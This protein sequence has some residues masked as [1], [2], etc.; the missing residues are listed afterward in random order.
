MKQLLLILFVA[1]ILLSCGKEDGKKDV[2]S[3]QIK[4]ISLDA[5]QRNIKAWDTTSITVI[6]TGENLSYAWEANHGDIKGSGIH[7]KYAAGN[8]CIGMNTI[9]CKVFNETGFVEDTIQIRVR[10]YLED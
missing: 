9:T 4:I 7:I 8:C 10:H 1:L 6:A 5:S 2:V 3:D